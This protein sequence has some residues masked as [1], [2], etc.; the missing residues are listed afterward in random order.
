MQSSLTK[1][2]LIQ[3]EFQLKYFSLES[4]VNY[5]QCF[6]GCLNLF[7]LFIHRFPLIL[8]GG[9]CLDRYLRDW[10]HFSSYRTDPWPGRGERFQ[11]F[12]VGV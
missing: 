3:I 8:G 12:I 2:G 7:D 11:V 6:D 1:N 9:G 10:W 5:S 4:E